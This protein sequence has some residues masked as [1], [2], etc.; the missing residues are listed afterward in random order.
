MDIILAVGVLPDQDGF[1][2]PIIP[3]EGFHMV[4]LVGV[5]F[6]LPPTG[7]FLTDALIIHIDTVVL[8][9]PH[10]IG[11]LGAAI[12]FHSVETGTRLRAGLLPLT[13]R[14]VRRVF[15]SL[16]L[17]VVLLLREGYHLVKIQ[18]GE[19]FI[20]VTEAGALDGCCF[21]IVHQIGQAEGYQIGAD[22]HGV[23]AV[24]GGAERQGDMR[25]VGEI[26]LLLK[27]FHAVGVDEP[28]CPL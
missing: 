7:K 19:K 11:D 2:L 6:R 10:A 24:A 4:Q 12:Q 15:L 5:F 22:L 3:G 20:Q 25:E 1:A 18:V 13:G 8:V 16:A 21:R 23:G 9:I 26:G 28:F 17:F 27:D 14:C